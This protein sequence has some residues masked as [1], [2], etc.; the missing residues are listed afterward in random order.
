MD[1]VLMLMGVIINRGD[2]RN[3][4]LGFCM[5]GIIILLKMDLGTSICMHATAALEEGKDMHAAAALGAACMRT[6]VIKVA[7][8]W[9]TA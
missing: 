8:Q 9:K 5:R 4:L 1:F 2:R 7:R 3:F 6:Y